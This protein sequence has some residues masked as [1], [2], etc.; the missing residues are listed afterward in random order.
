MVDVKAARYDSKRLH[1]NYH[2]KLQIP[3]VC[4]KS[5]EERTNSSSFNLHPCNRPNIKHKAGSVED[6]T[7]DKRPGPHK[8]MALRRPHQQRHWT[9]VSIGNNPTI[10]EASTI[11]QISLHHHT[12]TFSTFD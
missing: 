8:D 9:T 12:L 5:I 10:E 2:W 4:C 6:S 11:D 1:R 3:V 7:F